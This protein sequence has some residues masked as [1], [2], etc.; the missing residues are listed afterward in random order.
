MQFPAVLRGLLALDWTEQ[1]FTS[2]PTQYRL[3][4]RR[5]LQVKIPNQQYQSTEGTNSTQTN[6]TYNKQT[7]TQNTASPLVYNNMRWIGDGSHRGEGLP[8]LNGGRAAAAVTPLLALFSLFVVDLLSRSQFLLTLPTRHP[9]YFDAHL[10]K[11]R[12]AYFQKVG[13]R[14][15][16]STWLRQ[17]IKKAQSVQRTKENIYKE[18]PVGR[19]TTSWTGT[20]NTRLV[21]R[22]IYQLACFLEGKTI[23]AGCLW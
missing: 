2:P 11:L 15:P 17:W 5:F 16:D 18:L 20:M 6:Q 22:P 21:Y 7:R 9:Q 4:G 19:N 12:D 13:V 23:K 14:T 3:Y 10:D 1:C 8:G